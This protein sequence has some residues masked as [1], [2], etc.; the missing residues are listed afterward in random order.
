MVTLADE[1]R[2]HLESA[3]KC[4]DLAIEEGGRVKSEHAAATAALL[5]IAKALIGIGLLLAAK[6][7]E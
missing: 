1:A 3:K 5:A 7:I 2:N 4:V 6:K